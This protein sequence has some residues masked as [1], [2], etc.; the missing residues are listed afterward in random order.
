MSSASEIQHAINMM[1]VNDPPSKPPMP[2]G[3]RWPRGVSANPGAKPKGGLTLAAKIRKR[4]QDGDEMIAYLRKVVLG[5]EKATARD[6]IAAAQ[7][8]FDRG[9]GKAIGMDLLIS[10]PIDTANPEHLELAAGVLESI[11][12]VTRTALPPSQATIEATITP[13]ETPN[14]ASPADDPEDQY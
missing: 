10:A 14:T 8:L 6:R 3:R 13:A 11:A 4:T 5:L 9:F 12:R 2:L 7:L 1:P